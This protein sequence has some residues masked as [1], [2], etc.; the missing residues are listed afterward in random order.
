M[1]CELSEALVFGGSGQIRDVFI[2]GTV[3]QLWVHGALS[4]LRRQKSPDVR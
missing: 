4:C 3:I 1:L 2:G